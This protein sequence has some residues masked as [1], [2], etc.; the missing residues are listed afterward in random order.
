MRVLCHLIMRTF[1]KD[2]D[3]LISAE[4]SFIGFKVLANA[5]GKKLY[6]KIKKIQI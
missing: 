6:E 4:K 1:L 5:S 3:E 2:K